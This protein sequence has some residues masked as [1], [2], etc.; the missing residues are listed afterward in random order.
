MTTWRSRRRGRPR[1]RS[2]R[3]P[4]AA[5]EL[6]L[7]SSHDTAAVHFSLTAETAGGDLEVS[8]GDLGPLDAGQQTTLSRTFQPQACGSASG[9]T[10]VPRSP[11]PAPAC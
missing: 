7:I 2:G 9:S 11:T 5:L 10:Y 8:S 4:D 1:H 3:Q 6:D